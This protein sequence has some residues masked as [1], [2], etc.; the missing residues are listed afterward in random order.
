MIPPRLGLLRLA[1]RLVLL[2]GARSKPN[3][4]LIAG[5]GVGAAMTDG[6]DPD[7]APACA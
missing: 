2:A 7:D 5:G 1:P 3:W 6:F 4:P